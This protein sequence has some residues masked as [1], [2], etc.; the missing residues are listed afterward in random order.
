MKRASLT[1]TGYDADTQVDRLKVEEERLLG[2]FSLQPKYLAL[3]RRGS[4][5]QCGGPARRHN[6]SCYSVV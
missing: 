4:R 6:V 3:L 5:P 1:L 2:Y